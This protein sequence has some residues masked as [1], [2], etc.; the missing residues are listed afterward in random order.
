[1]SYVVHK[2]VINNEVFDVIETESNIRIELSFTK[3]QA[4]LTARKLNLGRGF[5]NSQVPLF[6]ARQNKGTETTYK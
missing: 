3:K 6:F 4:N 5:G 1:M 2:S